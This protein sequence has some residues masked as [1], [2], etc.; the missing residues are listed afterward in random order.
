MRRMTF[1]SGT[2]N[3]SSWAMRAWLAL[4]EAGI[5]FDEEVVDIRRPQRF[6]NLEAIA[7]FSPP[8][9]VPV[10]VVDGQIIFDSIAIME[11][12]NDSSGDSLLPQDPVRR[13][14]A[15]AMVAWQHSGLSGICSRISFE[16][17][18][19]PF[20]RDLTPAEQSD[21][22]RLFAW[23]EQLLAASGGPFLFGAVSLADFALA[24]TVVRLKRH[25]P[26][27]AGWLRTS[28]W[29]DTLMGHPLV[30]EWLRA[31]DRL[32]HIWF[33]EYLLPGE[34]VKLRADG[35]R[36]GPAQEPEKRDPSCNR[37]AVAEAGS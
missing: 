18:F 29:S 34:A 10:L 15:R 31:A 19:Y 36:H 14:Q 20:K 27:F 37:P 30:G 24:P 33:D 17:A 16:S 3:G 13:A 22:A 1:Y 4:K 9:T 8:G 12:A 35:G 32:P 7:R 28:S 21:C 6:V 11:F 5:E 2:K 23:L 25:R 26:D